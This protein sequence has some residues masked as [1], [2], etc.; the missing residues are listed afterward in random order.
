MRYHDVHQEQILHRVGGK[1]CGNT[2]NAWRA[3]AAGV[4]CW[5]QLAVSVPSHALASIAA[6]TADVAC[7]AS[8]VIKL[9]WL[10]GRMLLQ[11]PGMNSRASDVKIQMTD[12]ALPREKAR[13]SGGR[14][15]SIPDELREGRREVTARRRNAKKEAEECHLQ[16]LAKGPSRRQSATSSRRDRRLDG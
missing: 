8:G 10:E 12:S 11:D 15:C 6:R 4:G 7:G 2:T 16:I 14:P 1:F 3:A 13:L 9:V 5:A